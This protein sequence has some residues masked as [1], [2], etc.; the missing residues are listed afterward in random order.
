[1]ERNREKQKLG[2]ISLCKEIDF[3]LL[4]EC[5]EGSVSTYIIRQ[6]IPNLWSIISKAE[7]KM[8]SRLTY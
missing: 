1:M 2:W 6:I 7:V 3:K 8:L 5:A 4:S